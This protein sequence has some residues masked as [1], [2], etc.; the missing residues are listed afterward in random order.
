MTVTTELIEA[1]EQAGLSLISQSQD[2]LAPDTR[3]LHREVLRAFL[4]SGAAPSLSWLHG[5]ASRL[6]L[7]P[8]AALREL[9]EADLVHLAGSSVVIAY[10]FSGVPTSD[11]VQLEGGPPNY[12][13]CAIDALGIPLM[14]GRDGVISS[15]DPGTGEPIRVVRN[16]TDWEWT[17]TSTV[18]VAGIA[19]SCETAAEACCPHVAFYTSAEVAESYLRAHPEI[20][21]SVLNHSEALELADAAF[22][23]L[24]RGSASQAES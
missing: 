10:P 23:W 2:K 21:G 1:A 9:A 4:D 7:E 22:G 3:A 15:T 18:V 20:S 11:R 13:M 5:Q 19:Q 17:P 24:L 16:S 8:D 6:G 14:T 12:A